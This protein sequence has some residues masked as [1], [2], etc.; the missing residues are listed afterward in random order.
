MKTAITTGMVT[1]ALLLVASPLQAGKGKVLY[2]N[3]C[4]KCH[5]TEVFT[6]D[7]RGVKS[8]G[9]LENRVKQCSVAADS[10]WTDDE[11]KIVVDYLN[12]DFYKF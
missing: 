11:I 6:R 9:G 5:S 1:L 7:D 12:K 10:K 3:S 4:T 2:D 8:L